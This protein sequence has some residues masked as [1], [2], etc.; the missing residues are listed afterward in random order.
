LFQ[1]MDE[2]TYAQIRDE[3]VSTVTRY[4]PKLKIEKVE[5]TTNESQNLIGIRISYSISD[6]I[7]KESDE[8]NI[9]F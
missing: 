6:G 4:I 2:V 1:P 9:L 8:V 3:I 5:T 7:L